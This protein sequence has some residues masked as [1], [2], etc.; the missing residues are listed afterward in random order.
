MEQ[1]LRFQ[2]DSARC[3][4]KGMF[5]CLKFNRLSLHVFSE[6]FVSNLFAQFKR[7]L[8]YEIFEA[9]GKDFIKIFSF[10]QTS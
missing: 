2:G 6:Q 3:G 4:L 9:H 8:S 5:K 1:P 7:G 10:L